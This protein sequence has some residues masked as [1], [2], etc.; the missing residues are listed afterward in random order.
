M[1]TGR[2]LYSYMHTLVHQGVWG[3]WIRIGDTRGDWDG[4]C[5]NFTEQPQA[6]STMSPATR[7]LYSDDWWT[8]V[9][10]RLANFIWL[11]HS[12]PISPT[13]VRST[14]PLENEVWYERANYDTQRVNDVRTYE[15]YFANL[16]FRSFVLVWFVGL[17][18][19]KLRK[20][21]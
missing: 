14:H 5:L 8:L 9:Y 20:L 16:H 19:K 3:G 1:H 15:L 2:R 11:R 10:A 17:Y 4:K 21:S 13:F 12:L 18:L 7:I 6:R